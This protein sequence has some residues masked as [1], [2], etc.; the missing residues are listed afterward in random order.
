M[1]QQ[2]VLVGRLGADPEVRYT[3]DG[4]PVAN[5]R[6]AT[7]YNWNDK[8]GQR[9]QK[10]EWHRCVSWGKL[11]EICGEHLYKGRQVFVEGRLQTREWT[12]KD[13]IKRYTTEIIASQVRFLGPKQQQNQTS[14]SSSSQEDASQEDQLA[15]AEAEAYT[16]NTLGSDQ[17]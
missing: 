13:N 8:N 16:A 4:K 7:S 3:P 1:Y 14:Q 6:V 17:Y 11:A 2:T 12:D 5:F 9:Q 10:T 15:Q